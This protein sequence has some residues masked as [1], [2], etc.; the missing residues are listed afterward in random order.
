ML[1]QAGLK[2][3]LSINITIKEQSEYNYLVTQE[4]KYLLEAHVVNS[5]VKHG[6]V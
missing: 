2:F 1:T 6:T 5:A 4:T 3:I